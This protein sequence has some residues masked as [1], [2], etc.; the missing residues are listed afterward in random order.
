M[1]KK[2][3]FSFLGTGAYRN[4][5]YFFPTATERTVYPTPL[6]QLAIQQY[7]EEYKEFGTSD[8]HILLLTDAARQKNY[9]SAVKPHGSDGPS[10]RGLKSEL[11]AKQFATPTKPISVPSGHDRDSLIDVFD[12]IVDEVR[13]GDEVYL[14]ITHGFRSLPLLA[15]VLANFLR[16]AKNATVGAI[17]YGAFED[18]DNHDGRAPIYDLSYFIELQE[19]SMATYGYMTYGF[20]EP[21]LNLGGGETS[22]LL[23]SSRGKHVSAKAVNQLL[24]SA[25]ELG[26]QIR[27]NRGHELYRGG[28]AQ[29]IQDQASLLSGDSV[30]ERGPIA[31]LMDKIADKN[32]GF[33]PEGSLNWL[34]AARLAFDDGLVQQTCSLL[35]EGAVSYVCRVNDLNPGSREDRET[36]E[37][38]LNLLAGNVPENKW[39]PVDKQR[40]GFSAVMNNEVTHQIRSLFSSLTPYRDD[41][42]HAG[43]YTEEGDHNARPANRIINQIDKVLK[44]FETLL[45]P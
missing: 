6:V 4:T 10:H 37:K 39:A 44:G 36:A 32:A 25:Y 2:I 13:E 24:K 20:V 27:T 21:L 26:K 11:T 5:E 22:E 8:R 31:L 18:K 9:L 16:V 45:L 23:R 1:A 33:Q 40:H 34:R 19:W 7:L 14:D 29:S 43:Y 35:R 30:I 38:V 17:Y 3:S 41:L 42:M 28:A 12:K 15:V